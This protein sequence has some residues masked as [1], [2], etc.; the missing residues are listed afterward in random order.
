[1]LIFRAVF[2]NFHKKKYTI[3]LTISNRI[4]FLVFTDF[5]DLSI[6]NFAAGSEVC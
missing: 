5:S 4:C 6:N 1:M 2:E 3:L